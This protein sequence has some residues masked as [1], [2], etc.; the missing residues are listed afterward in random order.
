MKK[1]IPKHKLVERRGIYYEVDSIVPF[2]GSTVE[3]HIFK[4]NELKKRENYNNGKRD[5]RWEEFNENGQ[6]E[7][8]TI[9]QDGK[10]GHIEIFDENGQLSW[11]GYP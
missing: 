3:Y 7:S 5:G 10:L 11:K 8:K 1:E 9:Y 4:K 2:T 6:L